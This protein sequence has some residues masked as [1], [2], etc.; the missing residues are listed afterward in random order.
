MAS[1]IAFLQS[2]RRPLNAAAA[3]F[4]AGLVGF[5]YLHLQTRLGLNPCPLCILQRAA[6]LLTGLIFLVAALHKPGRTGSRIYAVLIA[7]AALTGTGIAGWHVRLQHL[8]PD[9]VPECGPGLDYMLEVFPLSD[10]LKMVF[11]GSGECAD[12]VWSLLGLSIP[13][14][15]LLCFLGLAAAGLLLNWLPGGRSGR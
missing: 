2:W 15:S 8:P 12:I 10:T 14:W 6:F 5:A 1:L 13:A 7:L 3:V 9:R 11:T 4:C